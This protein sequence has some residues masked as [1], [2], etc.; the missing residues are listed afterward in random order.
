V[1]TIDT[2][3][4]FSDEE[5]LR[6]PDR[7]NRRHDPDVCSEI[8]HGYHKLLWSRPLPD[9]PRFRLVDVRGQ[10]RYLELVPEVEGNKKTFWLRSDA[11]MP[12]YTRWT[13]EPVAELCKQIN[14]GDRDK[15]YRDAYRIGA[16]MVFP[17][18][19]DGE[20]GRAWTMNQGRGCLVRIADRMDL[21]LE[22]IRRA[23]KADYATPL[24]GVLLR[25]DN[26]FNFFG[27]F[28]G[29][30]QHFLL[31]PLLEN[32]GRTVKQLLPFDDFQRPGWPTTP[33]E[34]VRLRDRSVEIINARSDLMRQEATRL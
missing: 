11:V 18:D 21:T 8:L 15:F 13:R 2:T 32:D 22:C 14:P 17:H 34:W 3:L 5:C 4:C 24:G 20:F 1:V 6:H 29:Y 23:Y 19:P 16:M 33:E 30:V 12:T 31:Q 25:Y 9:G 10:G 26:F 28:D 7:D 27:T